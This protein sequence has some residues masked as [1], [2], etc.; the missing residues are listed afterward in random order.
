MK[1]DTDELYTLS[2]FEITELYYKV[3]EAYREKHKQLNKTISRSLRESI[4][5]GGEVREV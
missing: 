2:G 5:D 1:F 3:R 4:L